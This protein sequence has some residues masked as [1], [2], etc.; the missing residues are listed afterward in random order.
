MRIVAMRKFSLAFLG[1]VSGVALSFLV[2]HP[3]GGA[4]AA[5]DLPAGQADA[6]TYRQLQ[7]FGDIFD[8]VRRAY[9]DKPDATKMID[10]AIDGM[11]KSL[12]P[13]SSY[14]DASTF[15]DM[16]EETS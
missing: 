16:Q 11:V 8:T 2:L 1:A 4:R 10:A 5:N 14:M 9:V 3:G 6:K 7:L 15:R 12:D 13:H